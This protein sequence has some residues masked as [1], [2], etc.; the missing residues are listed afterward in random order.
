MSYSLDI[1]DYSSKQRF[2]GATK[3]KIV[4]S[5]CISDYSEDNKNHIFLN[6]SNYKTLLKKTF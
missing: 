6:L 2:M 1:V 3:I 5:F 4:V